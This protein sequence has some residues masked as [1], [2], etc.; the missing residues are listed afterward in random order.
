MCLKESIQGFTN[1]K[2]ITTKS[3]TKR[4]LKKYSLNLIIVYMID[5]DSSTSIQKGGQKEKFTP[6]NL[7]E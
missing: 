2:K 7:T 3:K 5:V 1:Y 4:L 6:Y